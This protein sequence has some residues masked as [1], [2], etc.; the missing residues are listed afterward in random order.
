[1]KKHPKK[2]SILLAFII[3]FT[4]FLN[5]RISNSYGTEDIGLIE[6]QTYG[7]QTKGDPMFREGL[8]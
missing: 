7:N 6:V 4:T 8:L 2:I 5:F 3:V 1:M